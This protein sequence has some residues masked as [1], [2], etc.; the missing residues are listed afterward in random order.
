MR[1]PH[2][3]ALT[4]L[5]QRGGRRNFLSFFAVTA[6]LVD[7][8]IA[9]GRCKTAAFAFFARSTGF[10]Y[11]AQLPVVSQTGGYVRVTPCRLAWMSEGTVRF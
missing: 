1:R 6:D 2:N 5:Q 3:S 11:T 10:N 9:K 4:Q 7:A 8:A